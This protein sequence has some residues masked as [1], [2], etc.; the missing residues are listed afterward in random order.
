LF[1]VKGGTEFDP[2]NMIKLFSDK[3]KNNNQVILVNRKYV[4]RLWATYIYKK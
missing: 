2:E 4:F 1:G 3:N